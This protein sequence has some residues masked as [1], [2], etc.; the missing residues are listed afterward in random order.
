MQVRIS[1]SVFAASLLLAASPAFAL[2]PGAMRMADRDTMA[3]NALE[4]QGYAHFSNVRP[5]GRDF[6]AD[7]VRDGRTMHV[8]IVPE[9]GNITLQS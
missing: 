9:T 7:V 8:L 5:D 4:S 3:L 2:A 1:A 6:A